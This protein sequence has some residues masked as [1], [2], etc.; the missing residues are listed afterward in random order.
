VQY[1]TGAELLSILNCQMVPLL[2]QVFTGNFLL[3]IVYLGC[4]T[5]QRSVRLGYFLHLLVRGPL[6]FSGVFIAEEDD[7][8][9]DTGLR[10]TIVVD[11]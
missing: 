8:L 1:W 3:L 11:V 9:E 5:N 6:L 10:G 2:T 4:T 7:R